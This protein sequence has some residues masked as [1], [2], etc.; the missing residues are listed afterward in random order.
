MKHEQ[1]TPKGQASPTKKTL[2]LRNVDKLE[3]L[4]HT[5]REVREKGHKVTDGI[6]IDLALEYAYELKNNFVMWARGRLAEGQ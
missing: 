2:H 5:L 1:Q 4:K 6:V 3:E